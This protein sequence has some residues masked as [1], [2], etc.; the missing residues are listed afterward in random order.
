MENFLVEAGT[1]ALCCIDWGSTMQRRQLSEPPPARLTRNM[2]AMCDPIALEGR[3]QTALTQL[4]DS[5]ETFLATARLLYAPAPACPPQ[6]SHV[7]AILEGKV[8]SADIRVEANP[9]PDLDRLRALLVQ[10][11]PGRPAA[12]TYN[13][14][15]QVQVL[16]R[17]CTDPRVLGATRAGWEPWL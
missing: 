9:H 8:T 3:L 1:G 17:H 4:R 6:L 14:K 16:L 5:R 2:L 11:F 10:V 12:D 7:K 15:D 13:V